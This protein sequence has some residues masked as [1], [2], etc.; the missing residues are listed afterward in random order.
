M[1]STAATGADALRER[2]RQ[3]RLTSRKNGAPSTGA[4]ADDGQSDEAMVQQAFRG[5]LGGG[6]VTLFNRFD[7]V[8][9]ILMCGVFCAIAHHH[10]KVNVPLMLWEFAKPN[11][12]DGWFDGADG[13]AEGTGGTDL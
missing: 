2:I 10:Y 3:Q 1:S 9:L 12:D 13:P 4:K 11:Y 6:G 7:I 5:D 8:F